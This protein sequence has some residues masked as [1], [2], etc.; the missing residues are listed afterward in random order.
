[1][2]RLVVRNLRKDPPIQHPITNEY[3][4][5]ASPIYGLVL[6]CGF[7]YPALRSVRQTCPSRGEIMSEAQQAHAD[8]IENILNYYEKRGEDHARC[9]T[10]S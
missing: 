4:E 7:G 6:G 10:G 1:M 2:F 8:R 5:E 9:E 3:I